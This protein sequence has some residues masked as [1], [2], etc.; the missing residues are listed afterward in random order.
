MNI[1]RTFVL[2]AVHVL[3]WIVFIGLC[4]ETGGLLTTFV[5]SLIKGPEVVPYMYLDINLP[6][7][8]ASNLLFYVNMATSIVLLSGL[9]TYMAYLVTVIMGSFKYEKPFDAAIVR[10]VTRISHV[11]L[12]AGFLAIMV[13]GYAE[14]LQKKGYAIPQQWDGGEF[15]FLAGIIFIIANVLQKGVELQTENELTV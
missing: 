8:Q 4:I 9:K 11:A 14:W 12:G 10:Q 1:S 6:G 2:N 7:L 3:F 5:A 15:L 13:T